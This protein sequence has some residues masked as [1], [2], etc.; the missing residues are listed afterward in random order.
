[1]SRYIQFVL[2]LVIL[3]SVFF[4]SCKQEGAI[5]EA[6]PSLEAQK[7]Q[8]KADHKLFHATLR[9]HTTAISNRDIATLK[10]LMSPDGLMH[11]MRPN[12]AVVYSTDNYIK[13]H[14]SWFQDPNWSIKFTITDSEVGAEMGLAITEVMYEVPERDGKPYWN[15]MT[16]SFVMKK[17]DGAWYV[18]SDHSGS[19]KKSTDS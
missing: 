11:L 18:I 9:K 17:M 2:G 8:R 15:K 7:A 19:V 6:G 16:I 1:M 3:S 5:E 14:E 10:T 12:T 4:S 13:Y